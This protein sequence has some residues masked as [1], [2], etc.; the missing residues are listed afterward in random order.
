MDKYKGR[1]V[2]A[3]HDHSFILIVVHLTLYASLTD[4]SRTHSDNEQFLLWRGLER[5]Y[6]VKWKPPTSIVEQEEQEL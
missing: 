3:V 4:V 6:G 5:S 1:M 2:S